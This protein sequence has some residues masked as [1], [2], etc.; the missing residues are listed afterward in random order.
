MTLLRNRLSGSRLGNVG[1]ASWPVGKVGQASACQSC[2]VLQQFSF[3]ERCEDLI[4][5][6]AHALVRAA[7]TLVSTPGGISHWLVALLL[8]SA[9]DPAWRAAIAAP[10]ASRYPLSGGT[11]NRLPGSRADISSTS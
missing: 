10:T 4:S 5:L 6:V 7:S 8:L 9:R 2:S 3:F 1:P 11:S